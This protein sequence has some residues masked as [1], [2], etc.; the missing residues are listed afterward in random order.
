MHQTAIIRFIRHYFGWRNWSVFVYNTLIENVFVLFYV[1]LRHQLYSLRFVADFFIFVFFSAL[2]TSYG[3]LLNDLSDK[4]L[5]RVHGKSNTFSEDTFGKALLIVLF[6]LFLCIVFGIPFMMNRLFLPI[7]LGWLFLTTAYSARPFR[8]KEKG[9]LGL[10]C[11]VLAQRVL[12]VCWMYTAFSYYVW[13]DWIVFTT[14]ILFRGLSSDLN[15]QLEDYHKDMSTKTYTYAV[16]AGLRKAEKI[17]RFSLE[18]ENVLL[19]ISLLIIYLRLPQFR[20]HGVSLILPVL[21]VHA[22]SYGIAWR[23]MRFGGSNIDINPFKA[24]RKDI[25]QF[26]HH[27]FPSVLLPLYFLAVLACHSWVFLIPMLFLLFYRG[28]FS[29]G[30]ARYGTFH[31]LFRTV[32]SGFQNRRQ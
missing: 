17:F 1:A 2:C 13:S 32:R 29:M 16:E 23:K 12:P 6:F 7:W 24:G 18:S 27:A 25:F 3:Y 26:M 31:A 4:E 30:I 21:L 9:K 19:G 14:Y 11:V 28:F 5:D 10:I 20:F 22:L 15:H 8:L